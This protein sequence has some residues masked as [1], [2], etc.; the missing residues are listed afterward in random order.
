MM[1]EKW[2][3]VQSAESDIIWTAS[4]STGNFGDTLCHGSVVVNKLISL[5]LNVIYC[6]LVSYSV[7]TLVSCDEISI[8]FQNICMY[9]HCMILSTADHYFWLNSRLEILVHTYIRQLTDQ[10]FQ[11][12]PLFPVI[13]VRA[14]QSSLEILVQFSGPKLRWQTSIDQVESYNIVPL[15]SEL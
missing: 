10:Y 7:I 14:D 12:G 3:N 1:V 9:M 15:K 11:H 8:T 4:E 5:V 2:F 13:S 6:T